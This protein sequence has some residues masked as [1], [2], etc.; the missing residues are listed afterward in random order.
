MGNNSAKERYCVIG[1]GASGL[2]VAKTF[3]QR[4]IPFDCF[5]RESDIGGL[6]NEGT[7]SGRVY[8]TAHLV[9]SLGQTPFEDFPMPEDHPIYPSHRQVLGYFRDYAKEFD[10]LDDITFGADV[11]RIE[12]T[13]GGWHVKIR[14]Q[15]QPR[16][17][18]GVIVTNGHHDVPRMPSYPGTFKG[19]SLHSRDYRHPKQ[20]AGKRVLVVGGGNSACDIA[21]DAVHHAAEVNLS[22]R[23]G[24]FF[25]R[26]FMCGW[27]TDKVL[28]FFEALRLP[29]L[30]RQYIYMFGHRIITGPAHRYGLPTPEHRILDTHPTLNSE[31]PSHVAHGNITVKSDIKRFAGKTVHFED[32]SPL[33]LDQIIYATGYAISIPFMDDAHLLDDDGRPV[34]YLNVFHPEKDTLFAAGLVQANGSIWRLA[35][36]QAKLIANFIVAR[37]RGD[38]RAEW[39]GALKARG[40]QAEKIDTFMASERH[41]LER[42]Y[43]GY[44]RHLRS[45]IKRFG[46]VN[47]A[48]YPAGLSAPDI[49]P[50]RPPARLDV[51]ERQPAA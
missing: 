44:G 37:A 30:V 6:W 16:S 46:A 10:I 2:A 5:E 47:D 40:R 24:Y 20:L 39:F 22:I 13:E 31:L 23:H 42:D 38:E 7:P 15:R 50:A 49:S 17:Y 33:E 26:K 41:L 28:N 21:I 25:A 19:E 8:E 35:D 18:T 32:D 51:S 45:L 27:P 12:E 3:K 34:L 36:Y 48:R 11:E 14:G 29:R 43:Y 9:S 1:A 4:G